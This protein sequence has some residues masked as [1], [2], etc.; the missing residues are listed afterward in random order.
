MPIRPLALALTASLVLLL[1]GCDDGTSPSDLGGLDPVALARALDDF[2]APLPASGEARA[3]LQ[4][5][6]P[7]LAGAGISPVPPE[8]ST[9]ATGQTFAYDPETSDWAVDSSL[10]GAPPT[11]V[12]VLWYALDGTG[13]ITQP[14]EGMGRIDLRPIEGE[15]SDS[16][17]LTI[18]RTAG[19]VVLLDLVQVFEST[20]DATV[21][22]SFVAAGSYS[23]GTTTVD[24][25]ITSDASRNATTEDEDYL[26]RVGL[27]D[28]TTHYAL[29]VEGDVDGASGDVSDRITVTA[30][31]GGAATVLDMSFNTA[32][33]TGATDASGTLAHAG[34]V[35]ANVTV[36]G[37]SYR[38]TKPDDDPFPTGQAT[39]LNN[40]FSAM[41]RTGFLV[42]LNLP[43]YLP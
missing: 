14:L 6:L 34:Q 29:E 3:N 15:T 1:G 42:V 11:G 28:A 24:V 30:T 2:L 37:N 23:D 18:R 20:G 9:E 21:V 43:L 31:R 26:L 8:F 35:I 41:T 27:E 10:E 25:S 4:A 17:G 5:A 38:F 7:A 36:V 39:D 40:L 19:E 16:L 22:E 12:S 13:E 33:A 32:G